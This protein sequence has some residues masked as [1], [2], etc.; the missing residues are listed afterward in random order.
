M[1]QVLPPL[2]LPSSG[3]GI[4]GTTPLAMAG[5]VTGNTNTNIITKIRGNKVQ[6]ATYGALQD[7]YV[8]TWVN[9]D[10]YIEMKPGGSGGGGSWP[11]TEPGT[12]S[13]AAPIVIESTGSAVEIYGISGGGPGIII[14]SDDGVSFEANDSTI[15]INT[16]ITIE[17]EDGSI[18]ITSETDVNI[19]AEENI[20]INSQDGIDIH[21]N[22]VI[23]VNT[24]TAGSIALNVNSM[25]PVTY[26]NL[27]DN[28]VNIQGVNVNV[29]AQNNDI[30]TVNGS[31]FFTGP[32]RL[33]SIYTELENNSIGLSD[34]LNPFTI[35]FYEVS[36]YLSVTTPGSGGT[37][38]ATIGYTDNAGATT[39]VTPTLTFGSPGRVT[40]RFLVESNN[41]DA[42]TYST[43]AVGLAG[44]AQYSLRISV[45]RIG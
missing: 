39:Q 17:S 18:D 8:L 44:G 33:A 35:G 11:T 36:V 45:T 10:G 13:I 5:D 38:F 25:G 42:L 9:A 1:S 26:I 27:N 3:S 43:T 34:L 22:N 15:F 24:T 41:V 7:G 4:P 6:A 19:G 16:G 28:T 40:G 31:S 37:V 32:V 20:D 14:G 23:T 29:N 30:F 21:A 12:V 2:I